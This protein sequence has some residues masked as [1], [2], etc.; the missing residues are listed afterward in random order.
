MNKLLQ[1]IL[2]VLIM[3]ITAFA[4][5]FNDAI[6]AVFGEAT[7]YFT[8]QGTFDPGSNTITL[9]NVT[10]KNGEV[11]GDGEAYPLV[12]PGSKTVTNGDTD[13]TYTIVL[14]DTNT[15]S[16][17]I[18]FR[19]GSSNYPVALTLSDI[20]APENCRYMFYYCDGLNEVDLSD[21]DTSNVKDMGFLFQEC[22][23]LTK[24]DVSNFNT[25]NVTNMG[26]MFN[27]SKKLAKLDL[28]DFDTS[29]V[30]NMKGMFQYCSLLPELDLS[31]FNTSRVTT[32]YQMFEGCS[33]LTKLN[34]SS[35]NTSNVTTMYQMFQSCSSLKKVDISNFDTGKVT[36]VGRMFKQCTNLKVLKVSSDFPKNTSAAMGY[37]FSGRTTDNPNGKILIYSPDG[38]VNPRFEN[39][40]KTAESNKDIAMLLHLTLKAK[41]DTLTYNK[42]T[43]ISF[44]NEAGILFENNS[45]LQNVT[46]I[47]C[48]TN[49]G[50]KAYFVLADGATSAAIKN[51]FAVQH[52]NDFDGTENVYRIKQRGKI[53]GNYACITED[54]TETTE[55]SIENDSEIYLESLAELTENDTVV[56]AIHD[57]ESLEQNTVV[58][59]N[60][61][62]GPA[63]IVANISNN[64]DKDG[65]AATDIELQ[66]NSIKLSGDNSGVVNG[67]VIISGAN[68]EFVGNKSMF[69]VPLELTNN[70][71][72]KI[73]EFL[74]HE[75]DITVDKGSQLEIK[76]NVTFS[77]GTFRFGC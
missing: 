69:Q 54:G 70:S 24:L 28:S 38:T 47:E 52:D 20:S 73:S 23:F 41:A 39:F 58:I 4:N 34:L 17:N 32:M 12:I 77:G 22:H 65:Y 9:S 48:P 42:N 5:E 21:L 27:C 75:R 35:F 36:E 40:I 1:L 43:G 31:S 16:S 45:V 10:R 56:F 30:T 67:D 61:E 53:T 15:G 14:Q 18:I 29:K 8:F 71:K 50:E 37:M 46:T 59:K 19:F 3:S 72:V 68:I 64:V 49:E 62:D 51:I 2:V 25:S 44:N 74:N 6:S 60:E 26:Y 13:I 7:N 66:G 63:E 33:S 55:I 57:G 11:Y 76:E